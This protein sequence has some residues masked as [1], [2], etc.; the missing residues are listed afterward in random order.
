M[1]KKN[2]QPQNANHLLDTLLARY[3]LKNDAALARFVGIGP[4]QISKARHGKLRIT[5]GMQLAIMAVTNLGLDE[6]NAMLYQGT[7]QQ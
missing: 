2:H 3:Q 6:L 1:P 7:A 4:P 5:A